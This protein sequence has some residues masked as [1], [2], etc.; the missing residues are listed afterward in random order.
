MCT[1][2]LQIPIMC[3]NIL[4]YILHFLCCFNALHDILTLYPHPQAL[5]PVAL[6]VFVVIVYIY[7]FILVTD[8]GFIPYGNLL[9][10]VFLF[11]F[12]IIFHVGLIHCSHF[13]HLS[14]FSS[15][16]F[17]CILLLFITLDSKVSCRHMDHALMRG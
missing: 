4:W 6:D 11:I 16:L 7:E 2:D 8:H 1:G 5:L 14:V 17:Q 3:V 13:S 12:I 9:F 15:L 10:F